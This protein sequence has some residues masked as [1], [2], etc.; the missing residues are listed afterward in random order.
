MLAEKLFTLFRGRTDIALADSTN[1]RMECERSPL[2]AARIHDEHLSGERCLGFYLLDETDRVR[3]SAVDIDN[4][5]DKPDDRWREK[6]DTLY[7]AL[8]GVD[9]RP[10]VE[11]SQSGEGAHL[12]LFFSEPVDAWLIRCFWRGLAKKHDVGLKEI[13]PRQ[14]VLTGASVGNGIR[15]PLWNKSRFV[16]VENEWLTEDPETELDRVRTLD[17]SDL[18]NLCFQLGIELTPPATPNED[19]SKTEVPPRVRRLLVRE[20]TLLAKRWSGDATGMKDQSKSAIALSIAVE[21]VR[22][23]TPTPE[24]EVALKVWCKLHGANEKADRQDW[25]ARTIAK[26]YEFNTSRKED[27]SRH[28]TTFQQA[29]HAYIDMLEREEQRH[30]GTG[31]P[32]L[33]RSF[34]GVAAGEVCVI[35]A[36]PRNGKTAFALQWADHAAGKGIPCLYISEEMS[37]VE[38]GK[39]R[40]VSVSALPQE[41]WSKEKVPELRK[42]VN[43]YHEGRAPVFVVENCATVDRVE[44]QIDQFCTV[45]GVK[46]VAIDYLQLLGARG[47]GRYETVTDASQR[48]KQAARRNGCSILLMVQMNREVEKRCQPDEFDPKLS[49]LR[50]SGSIEQDADLV[51]FCQWPATVNPD[52]DPKNYRVVVAKRRNGPIRTQNIETE[53]NAERQRFGITQTWQSPACGEQSSEDD[54]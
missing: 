37:A 1:G 40:L 54:F 9:V 24:I 27:L 51:L 41:Q 4:H 50:D 33:D 45:H 20:W 2:S 53:F 36:R 18:K 15:Y 25:L 49:D 47:N 17:S 48:I 38:L 23:F 22:Q 21:L 16:N 30:I 6:A 13:Y 46:L 32:E 34:E 52:A 29:A 42:D 19:V 39:R 28:A 26:A 11:V 31:I 3:C 43:V 14:D 10:V 8:C 7:F 35:A 12:W 44:E 5:T